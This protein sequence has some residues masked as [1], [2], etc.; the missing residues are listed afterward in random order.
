MSG[1]TVTAGK[2][3]GFTMLMIALAIYTETVT[4]CTWALQFPNIKL[5]DFRP[6]LPV[7]LLSLYLETATSGSASGQ[8]SN[9]APFGIGAVCAG[10]LQQR[11]TAGLAL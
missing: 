1:V 5:P 8:S 7:A 9:E 11:G 2:C 4:H 6:T 10:P 3:K